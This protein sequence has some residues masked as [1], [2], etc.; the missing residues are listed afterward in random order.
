MPVIL[1]FSAIVISDVIM[2]TLIN[3]AENM[4]YFVFPELQ[5]IFINCRYSH[6]RIQGAVILPCLM[7]SK[8]EVPPKIFFED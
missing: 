1:S 4:I 8:K 6:S 2:L 5:Q 3:K 7:P